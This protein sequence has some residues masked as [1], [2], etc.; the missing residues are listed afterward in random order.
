MIPRGSEAEG[1]K[2]GKYIRV[3]HELVP[4]TEL[5]KCTVT[6]I[7]PLAMPVERTST[8]LATYSSV[9][10][11][12]ATPAVTSTSTTTTSSTSQPATLSVAPSTATT[13]SCSPY[14]ALV[15]AILYRAQVVVTKDGD[16]SPK[17]TIQEYADVS[18][19]SVSGTE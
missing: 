15:N 9:T 4:C 10:W 14:R 3:V 1:E 18:K 17:S 5:T 12:A 2:R 11:L 19:A 13:G 16:K 6:L 7:R 8:L